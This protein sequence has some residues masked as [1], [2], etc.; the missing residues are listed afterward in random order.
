MKHFT[1]EQ[2]DLEDRREFL[3]LI[4][5]KLKQKIRRKLLELDN[6][7]DKL[8]RMANECSKKIIFAKGKQLLRGRIG[9][10]KKEFEELG[11]YD[12]GLLGYGHDDHDLVKRAWKL[13]Y[14]MYWW[15]GQYCYRIRTSGKERNVNM[16]KKW[17][18]TEKENITK[19][20]KNI[21]AGKF[22]AN[23][24]QHWRKATLIKNF[25]EI[26]KI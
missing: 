21:E 7:N 26:I 16:E 14:S 17:R 22:K 3:L 24:G 9:F 12:E 8:N 5:V 6:Q 13:K 15:G 19:S 4:I 23:E 25:N 18:T 10:Y 11:G 20:A 2:Q 1:K